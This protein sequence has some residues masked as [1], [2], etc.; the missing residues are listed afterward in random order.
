MRLIF[1]INKAI[2]EGNAY[3]FLDSL[4]CLNL[5]SKG[6]SPV[7]FQA[8]L[9]QFLYE[10]KEPKATPP[11]CAEC[12]TLSPSCPAVITIKSEKT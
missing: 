10:N 4:H 5:Y 7:V 3:F 8:P 2:T 1:N 6:K 9:Y 12:P 11:K